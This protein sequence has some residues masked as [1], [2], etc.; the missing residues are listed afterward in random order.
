[1]SDFNNQTESTQ[2]KFTNPTS[3]AFGQN[4]Q[5]MFGSNSDMPPKPNNNMVLAIV[6][7]VVGVCTCIGSILG[8]I[9][10]VFSSQVD[11]KYNLGDYVGAES[12]AKNSKTLSIIGLIISIVLIIAYI[13]FQ[14]FAAIMITGGAGRGLFDYY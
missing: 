2:E 5:S 12:T 13:I 10:I 11:S 4:S 6:C 3:S 14:I 8:I 9:A 7:T 1:M